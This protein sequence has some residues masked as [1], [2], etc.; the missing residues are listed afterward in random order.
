MEPGGNADG[1]LGHLEARLLD[2]LLLERHLTGSLKESLR[3]LGSTAAEGVTL[4]NGMAQNG[5]GHEAGKH[6][7]LV[8]HGC[9]GENE[10]LEDV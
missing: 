4:V 3:R 1:G 6:G 10:R 7:G 5:G 8:E 9:G 2:S